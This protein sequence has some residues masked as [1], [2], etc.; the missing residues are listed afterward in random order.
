MWDKLIKKHENIVMVVSGHVP[1]EDI[2]I[3]QVEG[4]NGNMITQLLID[5]QGVDVSD[6]STGLIALF[7]FSADGKNVS[8]EYYSPIKER[9]FKENNQ[10][11][12]TVNCLGGNATDEE[13]IEPEKPKADFVPIIIAIVAFV[14]LASGATIFIIRKQLY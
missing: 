13:P 4:D 12:F 7:H 5:P 2:V 6:G 3:S 1:Y 11:E 14:I 8:V 10:I 9:Y